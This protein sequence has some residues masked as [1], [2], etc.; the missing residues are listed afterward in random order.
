LRVAG[1]A[2]KVDLC[3][4]L[5][6]GLLN[7][8]RESF[9]LYLNDVGLLATSLDS[10][11]RTHLFDPTSFDNLNHFY[12]NFV[13]RELKYLGNSLRYYKA[14]QHGEIEF[15]YYDETIESIA[16]VEVKYGNSSITHT[17]LDYL[18]KTYPN[19]KRAY[20][21]TNANV[22]VVGKIVYLPIW[23]IG[24]IPE[25]DFSTFPKYVKPVLEE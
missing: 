5:V 24:L 1:C 7:S 20:V 17:S 10:S 9:K 11:I 15:V 4:D 12:E 3:N 25:F 21:L 14:K 8:D 22:K 19:I 18:L 2:I 23:S 6:G 16:P 13:C